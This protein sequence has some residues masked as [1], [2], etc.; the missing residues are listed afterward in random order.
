MNRKMI[1]NDGLDSWTEEELLCMKYLNVCYGKGGG[2]APPPQP[3]SVSQ[4]TTSE[5]PTELRPFI[6][7]IFEKSQAIQE[8]RQEEGFQ[9]ELTQQLA[10]F[11]PEQEASFQGIQNVVGQSQPLFNEAT[12]LARQSGRAATDPAEIAALMNPFLRNVTDIQ[13]REAQRVGDVQEQQLAAQASQA[14]AFGGSRAAILEAERQRNLNQQ[15]GD[16]EAQG[17]AASFQNAQNQLQN[18]FGR[19]SASAAQLGSLGAAIP[20][21]QSECF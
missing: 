20:A 16:I 13:K 10:S 6:S 1:W 21:Q 15:L 18:Q 14:G 19:E 3:S 4:T 12:T 9:P 7:D 5:F 2:S 11:T 17:L 8:Q